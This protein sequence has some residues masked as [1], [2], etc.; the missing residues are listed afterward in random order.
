MKPFLTS[1]LLL[2]ATLLLAVEVEIRPAQPLAGEVFQLFLTAEKGYPDPVKLPQTAGVRW[3]QNSTSR[4]YR[5][6]NGKASYSL[7]IAAIAARPGT[8]QIPSFQVKEPKGKMSSTPVVTLKVLADD[9]ESPEDS[10]TALYG[11]IRLSDDRKSYYLGEEVGL[12]VDLFIRTD[13]QVAGLSYPD[14]QML[15][16]LHTLL[17]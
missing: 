12:T 5:N 17:V 9:A 1:F 16:S 14:L 8:Y 11:S 4:S 15:H 7:G 3:L 13:A 2:T 6:I 10:R